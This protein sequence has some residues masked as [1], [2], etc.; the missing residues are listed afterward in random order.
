M[1]KAI[2]F[3][4]FG[5]ILT[6]ALKAICNSLQKTNPQKAGQIT[7]IITENNRGL[8]SAGNSSDKIAKILGLTADEFRQQIKDGEVKDQSILDFIASL[9]PNFRTA[10]LSNISSTGLEH[11]FMPDELKIY[12]DV[13]VAS[14][15]I[16]F[17]KPEAQAYEITADKLGVRLNECI[18]IDDVESYCLGAEGVGMQAI[19]YQSFDQMKKELEVLLKLQLP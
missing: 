2:I 9:R 3:D 8:I 12:F 14:G 17:A 1:T 7:E 6:D 18:M 19:H 10:M 16:G 4:C 5:V 15:Q 13:V 11:R